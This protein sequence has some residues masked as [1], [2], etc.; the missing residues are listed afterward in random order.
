MY[1]KISILLLSLSIFGI[2]F[3]GCFNSDKEDTETKTKEGLV[4]WH[5]MTDRHE[6]FLK[7]ATQY[8]KE[9]GIAVSFQLNAPSDLY[10]TK[11]RGAAQTGTLP[12]IYGVLG[13]IQDMARFAN[14]KYLYRFDDDLNAD[15]MAWKNEFFEKALS[16]NAFAENNQWDVPAG[17]YGIPIDVTNIQMLYNK[18]I[19]TE[20]GITEIPKTWDEFVSAGKK[21]KENTNYHFFVS[22]F[23]ETWLINSMVRTLAINSL[24]LDNYIKTIKGEMNYNTPEWIKVFEAFK[25]MADNELFASGIVTM[26]NKSA[27]RLFATGKAAVTFNG[28]WCVNVYKGMNPNLDY[29][30]MFFPSINPENPMLIHGGAGSSFVVNADSPKKEMA[31]SFL[32]WLTA[33]ESQQTLALDTNNLPANK[34]AI[35][36]IPGLL[37]SFAEKMDQ[38]IHPSSMEMVEF[39]ELEEMIGK[40][41]QS[42]IIEEKTSQGLAEELDQVKSKLTKEKAM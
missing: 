37:V 4:I 13:G 31:V 17:T 18:N 40:G 23:G 28:S 32:K 20:A 36:Q 2:L 38:S 6:T 8:E 22:G 25:S 1:K 14:K 42:I 7:L 12:E 9:T 34:N 11:V 35:S 10:T 33:K 30:A 16:M 21:I 39:A 26:V 27:E 41:I 19:F 3:S 15:N 24:G 5:W 29:A